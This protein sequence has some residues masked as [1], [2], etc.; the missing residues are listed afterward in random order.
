MESKARRKLWHTTRGTPEF[1]QYR[2]GGSALNGLN[3]QKTKELMES[4]GLPWDESDPYTI[5]RMTWLMV[6]LADH[7]IEILRFLRD[8]CGMTDTM[9]E[10][11][12]LGNISQRAELGDENQCV[13][14]DVGT[15]NCKA[16]W[17]GDSMPM[18]S[19]PSL[20]SKG[21]PIM[22]RGVISD[23]DGYQELLVKCF[24]KLKTEPSAQ[25]CFIIVA[26]KTPQHHKEKIAKYLFEELQVP[27]LFMCTSAYAGLCS[28]EKLS[29]L[30]VTLGAGIC[31][32]VPI[33]EGVT[34]QHAI[35]RS[36]IAGQDVNDFLTKRIF[37][38]GAK[39]TKKR[40]EEIKKWNCYI[41]ANFDKENFHL[42]ET[43]EII[44]S[45]S[46][47][48]REVPSLPA[49]I[50]KCIG[51]CDIDTRKALWEN[52]IICGGSTMFKGFIPRL[53][54]ELKKVCLET[55]DFKVI[56]SKNRMTTI[57]QGASNMC[58]WTEFGDWMISKGEWD[59]DKEEILNVKCTN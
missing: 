35:Q 13:I 37:D 54:A 26:P 56:A 38:S 40:I 22:D 41:P 46:I 21:Q 3:V 36:D 23:F 4:L 55:V 11:F 50:S 57:H 58:F 43:P 39:Q 28:T 24:A 44:F 18:I 17:A 31:H 14:I 30:V 52:I 49:L 59:I 2:K 48:Q 6:M 29:A 33:Y 34:I 19:I 45:P 47:I 5:D 25:T 42:H 8:V 12:N 10:E 9:E 27:N 15:A 32:V 1:Q 53:E 51:Q 16:G 20:N 7:P